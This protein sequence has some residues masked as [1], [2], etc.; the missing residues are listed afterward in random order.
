MMG[1]SL[2]GSTFIFRLHSHC[3]NNFYVYTWVRH[4]AAVYGGDYYDGDGDG[5]G[6]GGE[7]GGCQWQSLLWRW[8]L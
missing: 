1:L 6:D 8:L 7:G 2:L 5:D 3:F 4:A